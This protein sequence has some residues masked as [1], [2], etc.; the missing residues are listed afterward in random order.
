VITADDNVLPEI[1]AVVEKGTL[2]IRFVKDNLSNVEHHR[3]VKVTAR[4]IEHAGRRRLGRHRRGS[5]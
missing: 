2:K 3:A 4:T 5:R 1:E